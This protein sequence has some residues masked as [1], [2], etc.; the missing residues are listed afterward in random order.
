MVVAEVWVESVLVVVPWSAGSLVSE[1]VPVEGLVDDPWLEDAPVDEP[2]V[3]V[4]CEYGSSVGSGRVR[5]GIM[6]EPASGR[7]RVAVVG[8]LVVFTPLAP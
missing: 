8:L 5:A 7:V 3:E 1:P 6:P 2:P 4:P